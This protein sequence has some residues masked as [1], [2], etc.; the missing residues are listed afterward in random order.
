M[1]ALLVQGRGAVPVV[2]QYSPTGH[3]WHVAGAV[4]PSAVEYWPR[5]H[6]TQAVGAVAPTADD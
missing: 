1:A 3:V 2:A 6:E 4:A 5:R